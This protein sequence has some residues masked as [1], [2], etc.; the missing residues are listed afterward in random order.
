MVLRDMKHMPQISSGRG[1]HRA[2]ETLHR[3]GGSTTPLISF[4]IR[5]Q[6]KPSRSV[7]PLHFFILF[8]LRSSLSS[9]TRVKEISNV[10]GRGSG[11]GGTARGGGRDTGSTR[12]TTEAVTGKK[13]RTNAT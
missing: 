7:Q 12:Q 4:L 2:T 10:A 8:K 6:V 13:L 1:I 9:Y 5:G 3:D 11:S